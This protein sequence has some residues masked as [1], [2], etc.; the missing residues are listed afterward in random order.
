MASEEVVDV[1]VVALVE[2]SDLFHRVS[3]LTRFSS[4]A[5][6]RTACGR[7]ASAVVP[8]GEA[9]ADFDPCEGSGC[10]PRWR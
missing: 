4:G 8:R 1:A 2:G 3:D 7:E 9:P 5:V 10:W 6:A